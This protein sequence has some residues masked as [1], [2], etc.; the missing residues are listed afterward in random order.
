MPTPQARF[1]KLLNYISL[2][3][4]DTKQQYG[5]IVEIIGFK[6]DIQKMT[7]TLLDASKSKLVEA[8][9]DFVL[10]LPLPRCQSTRA[11]LRILGYAN[12]ALN[13]FP[14][15]KPALNSSYNKVAGCSFMGAP[16]FLNKQITNDLLWFADQ[17][18]CL[19]GVRML[20]AETWDAHDANL[21]ILGDASALG[22]AFWS[23]SHLA[24]YIADP[25]VDVEQNFNI[26]TMKLLPFL[27]C[28][29]GLLL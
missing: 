18:E 13:V 24:G 19:E 17:V 21:Q 5:K 14:L 4:E 15:L 10:N 26:F 11:W 23:P 12:W 28:L 8:I 9:R 3:H 1:L 2:P 25:I 6:V 29:S 22:L 16:I 7:I 27:L 20:E